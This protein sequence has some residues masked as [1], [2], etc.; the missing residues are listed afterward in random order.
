[1]TSQASAP[2]RANRVLL[3]VVGVIVAF[4]IVAAVVAANRTPA[5]LDPQTPEGVTQ[6]YLAALAANDLSTAAGFLDES[7]PCEI[8]DL[9]ATYVPTSIRVVLIDS[10][11]RDDGAAVTVEVTESGDSGPFGSGGYSHTE[12]FLLTAGDDGWRLRGAPW[13]LYDCYGRTR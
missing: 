6:A 13:P 2:N 5:T 12:R 9:A 11:V 3:L 8:G 10:T 4:A 7:S 1:M